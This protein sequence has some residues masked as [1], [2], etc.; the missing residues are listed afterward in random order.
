M[1]KLP[2]AVIITMVGTMIEEEQTPSPLEVEQAALMTVRVMGLELFSRNLI[3]TDSEN[4]AIF[5]NKDKKINELEEKINQQRKELKSLSTSQDNLKRTAKA[6][7]SE[8][9]NSEKQNKISVKLNEDLRGENNDLAAKHQNLSNTHQALAKDL[10]HRKKE[11]VDL[12]NKAATL[13]R[14]NNQLTT[15]HQDLSKLHQ[16]V[17]NAN[18]TLT[19][20]LQHRKKEMVDLNN[21][22]A[23]LEQK[24]KQQVIELGAVKKQ[25]IIET[26]DVISKF[27]TQKQYLLEMFNQ[28]NSPAA[29]QLL[30]KRIGA[31]LGLEAT[32]DSETL[33]PESC[34][35]A[36]IQQ[37]RQSVATMKVSA[38]VMAKEN[39]PASSSQDACSFGEINGVLKFAVADGVS[40]S[41]RQ[42]EWAQRLVRACVAGDEELPDRFIL[43]QHNH[44]IDGPNLSKLID[45]KLAWAWEE[46]LEQESHATL[47]IGSLAPNGTLQMSRQGDTWAAVK[48]GDEKDWEIVFN[49]SQING[50]KAITSRAPLSFEESSDLT[51]VSKIMLMTDGIASSSTPFLDKLWECVTVDSVEKME[52]FVVAG[53]ITGDFDTDDV[54][55]V[56]IKREANHHQ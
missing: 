2:S 13:H 4:Q 29:M 45:P 30:Q 37:L 11:I 51:N 33:L 31:P 16:T 36:S 17:N 34:R 46:K 6:M 20:E 15:K 55:I 38:A 39:Q 42:S 5:S 47:L 27:E 1:L 21:K 19:K 23:T 18:Q 22:A 53:R 40:K 49:P 25:A 14:E 41:N 48:I 3:F 24:N 8:F 56:A 9:K 52:D 32:H 43:A 26:E 28:R 54:T 12:N 35:A 50:T 10:L 7:E 44:G